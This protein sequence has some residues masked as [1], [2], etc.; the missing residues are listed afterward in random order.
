MPMSKQDAALLL[1][2]KG[3]KLS[4]QEKEELKKALSQ[5]DYLLLKK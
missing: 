4:K 3:K 5:S 2:V 1:R